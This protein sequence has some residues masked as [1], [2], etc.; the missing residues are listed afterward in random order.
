[1]TNDLS[2]NLWEL[3]TSHDGLKE[4]GFRVKT[5]RGSAGGDGVNLNE[6]E[7]NLFANLSDLRAELLSGIYK[8]ELFRK[9]RV[10]K[11]KPGLRMLTI[12]SIRD[13]IVHTSVALVLAPIFEAI[14][15]EGSFAYRP[16]RGV[17]KAVARI[18]TWRNRG[19][20]FVIEADIVGYFD[21]IDHA[22]LI[23]KLETT[24]KEKPGAPALIHLI[25]NILKDQG[26]AL[27]TPDKGVAQGSPLSPLLANLYLGKLDEEIEYQGVKIVR[28]ADDFVILCK[29]QNKAEKVLEHCIG[30]LEQHNLRLHNDG[31]RIVNFDRGFDFIGYLFLRTLALRKKTEPKTTL[32]E[33]PSQ[34]VISGEGILELSE[35]GSRWDPGTRVLYVMEPTY[36]LDIR[37]RSFSV[38]R[39]DGSELVSIP[40]RRIGRIEIGPGVSYSQNAISLAIENSIIISI[41]DGYGQTKGY[42]LKHDVKRAGIHMAQARAIIDDGFRLEIAKSITN[43]RI[44][45]QRTQL[46]RINRDKKSE[47]VKIILQSMQ[48]NLKNL[49]LVKSIDEIFGVEGHSSS[50]YWQAFGHLID[51]YDKNTFKRSRPALDKHN[52]GIN[53]LTG[54][55]ER[56]IRA[57]IHTSGLHDGFAFLHG[58]RDRH[59]G[60]VFDLMEPFRAPLSEGL[61]IYLFNSKRLRNDMFEN[62]FKGETNI[63]DE[64]RKALIIGYEASV[65]RRIS[66]TDK[67]GK[68]S[69]RSMMVYQAR[70]LTKAVLKNN[71][72]YFHPYL[73]NP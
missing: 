15:E 41:V 55:L 8:T 20:K 66:K 50:M 48:R 64:G 6:F 61:V 23:E 5:N 26:K 44:R 31:T 12:P 39:D 2:S 40:Y 47:E 29:S 70:G 62:N 57:S 3:A 28:F 37:N 27:G 53:F 4:A 10:P 25:R 69:W 45:N 51:N 49:P 73:M 30:V 63:N 42:V 56:D 11:R 67:A 71:L 38:K 33:V 13:R 34:P 68:L 65:K 24:L 22:I 60:L 46:M 9:I 36:N 14:F 52:A 58:S 32:L 35:K 7:T 19:Y 72:Q 1:M 21:N 43:A 17:H 59:N 54:V 18:E 16:Q